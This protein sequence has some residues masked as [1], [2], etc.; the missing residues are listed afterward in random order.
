MLRRE[1][2][3][4][5]HVWKAI[6]FHVRQNSLDVVDVDCCAETDELQTRSQAAPN[7]IKYTSSLF[8]LSITHFN[9]NL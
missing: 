3:Q 1:K 5:A 9:Y 7:E 6:T 2:D 8:A 4:G